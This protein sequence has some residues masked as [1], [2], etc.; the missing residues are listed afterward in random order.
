[1]P[2]DV[3]ELVARIRGG[4]TFKYLYFWGH[5]E[6]RPGDA[7][8][9]CLS[10]WYPS[11]FVL[12]GTQYPTAEHWMM[13]EKARLFGD[14]EVL[15]RILSARTPAEAKKLGG[16]VRGFEEQAWRERRVSIVAAGNF[17]KFNQNPAIGRF[18]IGTGDRVLVEASPI[19]RIWGIGLPHDDPR[20]EDPPAW[21]GL[22]LLGFALMDV[23]ERLR[24]GSMPPAT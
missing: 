21:R 7:G 22:N 24:A 14:G 9:S 13:A 8:A 2:M 12:G 6:R 11:G 10:Q 4:E 1:M 3:Q 19:D 16:L 20:A 17:F 5:Q 18:L 15:A 23:R